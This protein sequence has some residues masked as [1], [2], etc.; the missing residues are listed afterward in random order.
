MK[1]IILLLV[2]SVCVVSIQAQSITKIYGKINTLGD[3][4]Y[5]DL[6]QEAIYYTG[7]LSSISVHIACEVTNGSTALAAGDTI[8]INVMIAGSSI[9]DDSLFFEL[10]EPLGADETKR[11]VVLEALGNWVSAFTTVNDSTITIPIAGKIIRVIS[12]A[13]VTPVLTPKSVTA[14]FIK[15]STIAIT[16]A[17][18][19]KVK[20]YPNPVS[21]MLTIS[22]LK[23]TDVALYN[24]VGQRLL[25]FENVSGELPVE[26][27]EYPDG[28]Y[29]VKM[30]SG[31]SI[32]TEKVKLVK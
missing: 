16:E 28:L 18:M 23:N 31:K 26:M 10:D 32:R 30:Q 19:E 6:E 3:D 5:V 25:H 17:N 11:I 9:V 1:K 2:A 4:K 29:F 7:T 15:R 24:I 22:N 14:K 21:N 13:T 27:G 20:F 12:S 8:V